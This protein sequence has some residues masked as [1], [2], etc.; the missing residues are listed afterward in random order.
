MRLR[1]VALFALLALPVFAQG[2][3]R[4]DDARLGYTIELPSGFTDQGESSD[5]DGQI[6][7]VPGRAIE[8]SVWGGL[9]G[10]SDPDFEG[11]VSTGM[12]RDAEE[13]WNQTYQATTSRWAEWSAMAGGQ[14]LRQRRILLCDG[15][16][17]AA[18]RARYGTNDRAEM[19]PVVDRLATSL[20]GKAC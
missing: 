17:Y 3:Q 8:L 2:P 13:G 19:D 4:Y 18:F 6:F 14:V 15:R 20:R 12:A 11:M 5:G 16:S 7:A 10:G 9:L 1:L